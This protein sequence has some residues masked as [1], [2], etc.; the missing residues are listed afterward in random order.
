MGREIAK[1]YL[2][3][4]AIAALGSHVW[5]A[6][7]TEKAPTFA[8]DIAPIIYRNCSICHQ[9]NGSGPF[10]LITYEEIK[11]RA[12]QISEVTE[13]RFMPPWKPKSEYGP[14]LQGDRR[15]SEAEIDILNDWYESGTP[16]G[17]LEDTPEPPSNPEGWTL[18]EPDMV[19]SF[20]GPFELRPD[21]EDIF[22]NFVIP[23]P[24]EKRVYV[25][26][27]E[28]RPQTALAI[29]HAGIM[30]DTTGRGR[31]Q[32][33][34]DK[35]MGFPSMDLGDF[36]NP[37]GHIIGWTPGQIPYETYPGTAWKIEPGTDLILQLH[38]LPSGKKELIS[39]KIALY[40]SDDE[41]VRATTVVQL[42]ELEIDIEPGEHEYRIHESITLPSPTSILRI[43]PHAHYLG[44]DIQVYADLPNGQRRGL[45]QIPDWDFNW[46]SDYTFVEP[47]DL[48]AGTQL[49]MDFSYDNSEENIRNPS[50][51]PQRVKWGWQST[52]EMGGI[53]VQL[54][55]KNPNDKVIIQEAQ[56]RYDL[57]KFG[58]QPY[59]LHSL[60]AAL[61]DQGRPSEATETYREL[62][63]KEPSNGTAHREFASLL[64]EQKNWT[65][66][67]K[68][69]IHYLDL[70][71]QNQ[72]ARIALAGIHSRLNENYLAIRALKLG[73]EWFSN[74]QEYLLALGNAYLNIG[75]NTAALAQFETAT[76]LP[77]NA[78]SDSATNAALWYK[79]AYLNL[80]N[81]KS[82]VAET[83]AQ[84]AVD[85]DPSHFGARLMLTYFALE[86]NDR[87]KAKEQLHAIFEYTPKDEANTQT[88]LARLPF[89]SGTIILS[90]V[91]TESGMTQE[92]A[93]ILGEAANKALNAG[94][95]ALA[96][97]LRKLVRQIDRQ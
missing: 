71:P 37:D 97:K 45:L 22:R 8:D 66:A 56:A 52:D 46:Q 2:S 86:K 12:R 85:L 24:T 94:N 41:P 83:A 59:L 57:T 20:E 28:F 81:S 70:Y 49:M 4:A 5:L 88:I 32:D 9:T 35:E 60:A 36:G 50:S 26:A 58:R 16:T 91:L 17:N 92:A 44:K 40:F 65:E 19:L 25:R 29:H 96:E 84:T 31:S 15:L 13:D 63:A 3:S 34:E 11:K 78:N 79:I 55:L 67:G 68:H 61:K 48:P 38:M 90:E 75:D 47:V 53:V 95:S 74:D 39:P 82:L 62:L 21:G 33:T 51:P 76:Q 77:P 54:L 64:I 1:S 87:T 7:A 72:S 93:Q 43:F 14:P 42:R 80:N 89:P 30:T 10:N 6:D 27:L 73:L 69:L 23:I 18:G